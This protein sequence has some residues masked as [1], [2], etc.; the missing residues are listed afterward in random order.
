MI[1]LLGL[2]H[3]LHGHLYNHRHDLRLQ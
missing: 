2:R 3:S 1:Y